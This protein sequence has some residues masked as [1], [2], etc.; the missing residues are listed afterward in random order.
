M[1]AGGRPG[2]TSVRETAAG[3]SFERYVR[4]LPGGLAAYPPS[5]AKG[6]LVRTFL[7]G[8]SADVLRR[9]PAPLQHLVSDPPIDSDWIPEAQFCALLHALGEARDLPD[10][11][12]LAWIRARNRTLF[13]GPLYRLLMTVISPERALRQAANRWG[14][15]HRGSTL[16]FD[17]FADDGARVTL[18][19]SPGLFDPFMQRAL[20][21][22]FAAALESARAREPSVEVEA[23]GPR[24][25]RYLARW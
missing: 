16:S 11:E 5:V 14:V 25:A 21:E 12:L 2:D 22:A 3:P 13:S 18:A 20:G 4:G 1:A 9:L 10:P 6:S 24:F 8:Q 7:E 15:F 19:F 17:G 23:A